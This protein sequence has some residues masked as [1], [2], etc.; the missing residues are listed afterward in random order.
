MVFSGGLKPGKLGWIDG[1]SRS[2]SRL[3]TGK[4]QFLREVNYQIQ[5]IS[6]GHGSQSHGKL[7]K[8]VVQECSRSY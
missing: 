6:M 2:F 7:P 3:P 4:S 5:W 8:R 1:F